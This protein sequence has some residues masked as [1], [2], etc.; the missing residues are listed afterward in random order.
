MKG[1]QRARK[2]MLMMQMQEIDCTGESLKVRVPG[3]DKTRCGFCY[4]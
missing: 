4:L 3:D 2:W 1:N